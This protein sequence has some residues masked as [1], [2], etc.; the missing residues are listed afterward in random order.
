MNSLRVRHLENALIQY[1]KIGN[2]RM[3]LDY[4]LRYY[5]Y[6][7]K[8]TS[9]SKG[10]ISDQIY[11]IF[12]WKSLIEY[13][14]SP[15]H[16]WPSLLR[17]YLVDQR[18]RS[19]T[20][21]ESI[22]TNIRCS[23]PRELFEK[24]E[25]LYENKRAVHICNV[26]NEKPVTY[27]RVNVN[28]TSRD[29]IYKHL[30]H[31][32][33]RVEKCAE[34]DCGLIVSEKKCLFE[35]PEYRNGLVEIQDES[36]QLAAKRVCVMPG[37]HVMDYC[38]GT[39]G[40]SVLIGQ[41]MTQKGRL[42]LHDVNQNFLRIAKRRLRR[43]GITNYHILDPNFE[44]KNLKNKMNWVIVDVPC[45]ASGAYRRNPENKWH[46][47]PKKLDTLVVKQREIFENALYYLKPGGK[48]LYI[49]C[50]LFKDENEAQVDYFCKRFDMELCEPSLFELPQS[51]GRDGY[52]VAILTR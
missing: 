34:S 27:L 6:S 50:S 35:T 20:A 31:K 7:N 40:K 25:F 1:E 14:T 38:A 36:T 45:T 4:F 32:G 3:A 18:W 2:G 9:S 17:T 33:V 30:L 37:D 22:P 44:L 13:A 19:L 51:K 49:T 16:S 10:W 24:L 23:V 26:I 48:L 42:Y 39:G 43:A 15:P 29:R 52:F 12:R 46:Y 5:F 47:T 28:K 21:N 41:N 11:H 8:L